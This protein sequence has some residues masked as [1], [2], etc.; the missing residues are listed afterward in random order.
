MDWKNDEEYKQAIFDLFQVGK[1]PSDKGF[2][3]SEES[4]H[5][6]YTEHA[7]RLVV[8]DVGELEC[9]EGFHREEIEPSIAGDSDF[10]VLSDFDDDDDEDDDDD[11]VTSGGFVQLQQLEMHEPANCTASLRPITID[12]SQEELVERLELTLQIADKLR[13][14]LRVLRRTE[15]QVN[16]ALREIGGNAAITVETWEQPVETSE[17]F[18]YIADG[19]DLRD[20]MMKNEALIV[21]LKQHLV[22]LGEKVMAQNALLRELMQ[23]V[24]S[25]RRIANLESF[26]K[27]DVC[28]GPG[29]I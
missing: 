6:G 11:V 21:R 5:F 18:K 29:S 2:A 17:E 14:D 1:F 19:R 22:S 24:A 10:T 8:L 13:D 12:E 3:Q 16:E 27:R 28:C 4:N 26:C 15:M 7:T 23:T 9:F 25:D 20:H